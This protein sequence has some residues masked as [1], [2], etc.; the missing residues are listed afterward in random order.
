M[1]DKRR[2][3]WAD[4]VQILYKYFVFGGYAPKVPILMGSEIIYL[5]IYLIIAICS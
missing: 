1:L 4:V 2:R 3:R 5:I